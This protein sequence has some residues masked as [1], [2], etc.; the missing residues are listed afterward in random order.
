MSSLSSSTGSTSNPVDGWSK[1]AKI[2]RGVD[3]AKIK[4]CKE[5]IDS[6]LVFVRTAHLS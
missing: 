1:V 3:E 2:V 5:D 6:L 4:D